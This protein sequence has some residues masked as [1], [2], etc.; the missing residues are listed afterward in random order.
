M[1]GWAGGR[2]REGFG[3]RTQATIR[4]SRCPR[5]FP[6]QTTQTT[7]TNNYHICQNRHHPPPQPRQPSKRQQPTSTNTNSRGRR[8]LS[9]A[10]AWTRPT[11]RSRRGWSRHR[12]AADC[13]PPWLQGEERGRGGAARR[14]RGGVLCPS[15]KNQGFRQQQQQAAV[16]VSAACVSLFALM[17]SIKAPQRPIPTSLA[18]APT[19]PPTPRALQGMPCGPGHSKFVFVS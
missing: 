16:P 8:A 9:P 15:P 14:A 2:G 3:R 5:P 17:A 6:P 13:P 12:D 1:Q 11:C 7:A 10:L 18:S 4:R 19:Q